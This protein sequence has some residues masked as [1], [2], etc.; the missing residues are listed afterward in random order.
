MRLVG[1]EMA[2]FD[3][4]G[5]VTKLEGL[6]IKLAA[7]PLA[8]GRFRIS[9]WKLPSAVEYADQIERLWA[10]EVGQNQARIDL[11]GRYISQITP[12]TSVLTSGEVDASS[13]TTPVKVSVEVGVRSNG[14]AATSIGPKATPPTSIST[15]GKIGSHGGEDAHSKKSGECCGDWVALLSTIATGKLGFRAEDSD[16]TF[17]AVRG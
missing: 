11:L 13:L 8:D 12:A 17:W 14:S 1:G 16:P 9:R 15:G 6:G 2:V 7:I 4:A 5:F 3:V 10:F